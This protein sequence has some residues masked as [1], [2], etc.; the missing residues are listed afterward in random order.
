[1]VLGSVNVWE[2]NVAYICRTGRFA[3][4]TMQA[5][6]SFET[7]ALPYRATTRYIPQDQTDFT[8]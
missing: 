7:Q 5:A 6:G 3:I 8:L 4:V 1:M 2:V